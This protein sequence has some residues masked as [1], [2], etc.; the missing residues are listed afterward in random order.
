MLFRAALVAAAVAAAS[1]GLP[2][3]ARAEPICPADH[4]ALAPA[5][6]PSYQDGYNSEHD[7]YA[8]PRNGS[9]LKNQMKQYGYTTERVCQLE[10]TGG[11]QPPSEKD[12]LLG[13]MDALHD[14]GFAP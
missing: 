3:P 6:S 14:L 4:C 7:Y 1:I 2:A 5:H 9:F 11:A 10:I 12:W 8:I 13:C